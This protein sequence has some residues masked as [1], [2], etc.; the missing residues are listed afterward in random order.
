M[1]PEKLNFKQWILKKPTSWVRL[2]TASLS[3]AAQ[4]RESSRLRKVASGLSP[5]K[6]EVATSIWLQAFIAGPSPEP[7]P[8]AAGFLYLPHTSCIQP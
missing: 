6:A 5:R 4:D 7:H 3:S 2:F 8:Y 1:H